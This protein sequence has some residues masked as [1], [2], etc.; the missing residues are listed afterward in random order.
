MCIMQSE[1]EISST[2]LYLAFKEVS[3]NTMRRVVVDQVGPGNAPGCLIRLVWVDRSR[4]VKVRGGAALKLPVNG[5]HCDL[6]RCCDGPEE[7]SSGSMH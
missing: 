6:A 3:S 4:L 5:G 2:Q 1:M 7:G